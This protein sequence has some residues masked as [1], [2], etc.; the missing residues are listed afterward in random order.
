[1]KTWFSFRAKVALW[2]AL[3][4][5]LVLV[6][7]AG[8]MLFIVYDHMLEEADY[9]LRKAAADAE[10]RAKENPE[11]IKNYLVPSE[12]TISAELVPLRYLSFTTPAGEELLKDS[13]WPRQKR[14]SFNKTQGNFHTYRQVHPHWS[15]HHYWRVAALQSHDGYRAVIAVSMQ[16]IIAEISRMARTHLTA[17]P[18]AL[19]VSGIIGWLVAGRAVRPVKVITNTAEIITAEGLDRRIPEPATQDEIGRLARV[20]NHMMARLENSFHQ[21]AR[22]SSNASHELRTPLTI[23]QGK[24]ENAIQ[25]ASDDGDSQ[26]VLVEMLEEVQRLKSITQSLLMFSKS[27][28]GQLAMHREPVSLGPL[29]SSIHQDTEILIEDSGMDI[30]FEFDQKENA[31]VIGDE[32]LLRMALFNLH[33]NAVKFNKDGGKITCSLEKQKN[34]AVIRVANT[35]SKISDEDRGRIFDRFFRTGSERR[36]EGFG[37]GLSLARVIVE[38]H[39]GAIRLLKSNDAL[40]RFEVVLPLK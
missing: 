2:T 7:F 28:S 27:D 5:G 39:K 6:V 17:L 1:M 37:L 32:R 21:A 24:L 40:N 35:G 19:L 36:I 33:Q 31:E 18:V 3:A 11:S 22:F 4:S 10:N 29:L 16:E 34:R 25:E 26:E 20:F 30:T 8:S 9:E 12:T 14:P 38:A 13:Y 15:D 23:M